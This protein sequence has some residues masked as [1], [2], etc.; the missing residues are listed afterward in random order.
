MTTLSTDDQNQN[1]TP[2]GGYYVYAYLNKT[3]GEPYYI[4]K[5]SKNRAFVWHKGISVPKDK[6]KIIFLESN[7]QESIALELEISYIKKYGRK[8]NNTGILLN[9]T[10][11]GERPPSHKGLK[12]TESHIQRII[13][14]KKGKPRSPETKA[15][16]SA[17]LMGRACSDEVAVAITRLLFSS[18]NEPLFHSLT[19][20][21]N[22][23][24]RC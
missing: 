19:P 3:T 8:D 13:D 10:D 11:G 16:I 2:K 1:L 14:S 5:G 18:S 6:S 15:K 22:H 20:C 12:R 23:R 21:C 4:G 7:L 24:G 17:S 9:R